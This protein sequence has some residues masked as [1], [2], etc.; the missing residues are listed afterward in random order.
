MSQLTY[1]AVF[2][3]YPF[4]IPQ[5]SDRLFAKE[6]NLLRDKMEKGIIFAR[7]SS[8]S[9]SEQNIETQIRICSEFFQNERYKT[10][11]RFLG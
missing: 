4:T 8:Q 1:T 3:T 2:S 11:Q 9:L 7:F 6:T 5:F 10:S